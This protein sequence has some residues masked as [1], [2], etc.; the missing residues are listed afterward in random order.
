MPALYTVGHGARS[1][2]EFL[3]ILQEAGI[4]LLVD[5]RR[6]PGSRRHPHFGREALSAGL[7]AAGIR[8]EWWGA[9]MGGRRTSDERS[10]ARHPAWENQAF[11]AYAAHMDTA[12]FR[13]K[14]NELLALSEGLRV[15]IMCAETLWWKCH[16]RLIADA[17]VA[18]GREA[19][20][21]GA[22][23]CRSHRLTESARV[24]ADGL[25][26]YDQVAP[27]GNA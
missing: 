19:I 21:L 20:H 16:R 23:E 26:A 9:S 12:Q 2:E 4:Q 1:L 27:G 5:V 24:D 17:I 25:L 18:A 11:R 7:D 3:G 8:Y 10:L 6:Y 15:A 14:L 22:G 13:Q